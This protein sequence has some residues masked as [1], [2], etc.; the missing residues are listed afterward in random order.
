MPSDTQDDALFVNALKDRGLL[1]EYSSKNKLPLKPKL[2]PTSDLKLPRGCY[3]RASIRDA[4]TAKHV[5]KI[6]Y[7]KTTDNKTNVYLVE[8]YSYD[9]AKQNG[10]IKKVL[11]AWDT[12]ENKIKCFVV[13]NIVKAE[14]TDKPYQV[15][16]PIKIARNIMDLVSRP[17]RQKKEDDN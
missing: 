4:A 11:W 1:K 17:R 9:Y 5:L 14:M 12:H 7:R 15:R 3:T 16:F 10:G 13:K 2:A 6:T 8:P